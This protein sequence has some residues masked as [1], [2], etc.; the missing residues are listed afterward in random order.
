[1]PSKCELFVLRDG[2]E[3][4]LYA[5][6]RHLSARINEA[7]LGA[8]S[9]RLYGGELSGEDREALRVLEDC[10]FFEP[11]PLPECPAN[12][13]VQVTLFPTDGC[14]L[15]CRYCYA[16]AAARR[17]LMP[18]ETGKA[19]IDYAADNARAQGYSDFVVAFHGNGEPFTAFSLVKELCR[20]AHEAAERTGLKPK[21]TAAT[22]GVLSEEQLDW[23]IAW[24]DGVNVSF[25]GTE[26]LQ[27]R[28]RPM[29]GG[30]E[31]FPFVDRTLRRLNDAGKQFGIRATLTAETVDRLPA[32]AAFVLE[33]YPACSPLHVEPAWEAG[34]GL[35]TG[36][37][38]PDPDVFVERFLE[39]DALLQ[40]RMRLVFSAARPE[41]L[42]LSFCSVCSDSFVVTAEGN[43]TSCYEVSE[44]SDPRSARYLYGRWDAD[45][46][47]FVFDEEKRAALHTLRVDNMPYCGDCFCKYHCSGDCAAK[48]L[49]LKSPAQHAGSDRCRIT[50]ALTLHQIRKSLEEQE[51]SDH[52]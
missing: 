44:H 39:A 14:N 11:A 50:R 18:L 33:H 37:R 51:A 24:F 15:R 9:R 6:L 27:N 10:G 22:N 46:A 45:T 12:P 41:N 30:G 34:R 5:P 23:L 32:I 31:S 13:P 20:Y 2:E 29:A 16:G 21:L 42:S 26:E 47:A 40:G 3:P 7:A 19:A 35:D 25:D 43:V 28:Q 1:M 36:V 48:L 49:G 38:T 17:H 8:V 52:E 4:I